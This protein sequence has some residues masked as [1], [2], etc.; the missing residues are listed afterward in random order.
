MG[1]EEQPVRGGSGDSGE[2]GGSGGRSEAG[3][4]T[5]SSRRGEGRRGGGAG[6][7]KVKLGN[8]ISMEGGDRRKREEL[9]ALSSEGIREETG[10]P[11]QRAL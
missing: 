4:S 6:I 8:V 7:R 5:N 9:G 11:N 3:R 1:D 2:E 10:W